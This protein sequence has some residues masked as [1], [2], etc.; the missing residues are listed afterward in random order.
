GGATDRSPHSTSLQTPVFP[1]IPKATTSSRHRSWA[2]IVAPVNRQ[3]PKV[4]SPWWWVLTSVRTGAGLTA[5]IAPRY[6]RVR[7]SVDVASIEIT[8]RG[9]VR[10]PV[11][12]RYQLP[13]GWI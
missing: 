5:A 10:K 12:F 11:L 13:S 7:R 4:W 2:T 3:L 6:A 1:G 8:P 9:L